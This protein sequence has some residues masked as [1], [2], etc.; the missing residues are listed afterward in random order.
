MAVVLVL[1]G[2]VLGFASALATL[3][4]TD[5]GLLAALGAWLSIGLG[6]SVLAIA[7]SILPRQT[8]H[9]SR[10]ASA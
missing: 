2:G 3:I 9:T 1:L 6:S 4:F 8:S 5:L 10:I 7:G